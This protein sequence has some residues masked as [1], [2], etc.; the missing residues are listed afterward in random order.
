[1]GKIKIE[2]CVGTPCYLMGARE[3]L[4]EMQNL[5]SQYEDKIRVIIS[6]C[7]DDCCDK[8]PVARVNGKIYEDMTPDKLRE[9][10]LKKI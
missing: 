2:G 3:L 9:I 4:D 10:V 5:A 7:I 6:H 1:M 8:A